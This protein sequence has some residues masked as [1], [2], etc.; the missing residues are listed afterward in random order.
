M[1]ALRTRQALTKR[2]ARYAVGVTLNTGAIVIGKSLDA[3]EALTGTVGTR[4]RH[5]IRV[6][7]D[8][9][10]G[11]VDEESVRVARTADVR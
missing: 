5:A 9:G 8:K 7:A 10:T 3:L 4:I 6:A 1:V 11:V 2:S